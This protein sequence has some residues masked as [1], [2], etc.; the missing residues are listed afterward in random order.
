MEEVKS[1]FPPFLSGAPQFK[2]VEPLSP[3]LKLKPKK[4]RREDPSSQDAEQKILKREEVRKAIQMSQ[5]FEMIEVHPLFAA[6]RLAARPGVLE[7]SRVK[8]V[9]PTSHGLTLQDGSSLD[10]DVAV[11]ASRA[12]TV[13]AQYVEEVPAALIGK[14]TLLITQLLHAGVHDSPHFAAIV[15]HADGKIKAV[16]ITLKGT[17]SDLLN[18]VSD[19]DDTDSAYETLEVGPI[20]VAARTLN[21]AYFQYETNTSRVPVTKETLEDLMFTQVHYSSFEPNEEQKQS[22]NLRQGI[23][24]RAKG[25]AN[26]QNLLFIKKLGSQATPKA[27]KAS[28]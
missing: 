11:F 15:P 9:H 5:K 18:N 2:P 14:E 6:G 27:N 24:L 3:K 26:D 22:K 1:P 4:K 20:A 8:A 21:Q 7:F 28:S 19:L 25:E 10:F 17:I 13:L 16:P 12:F 23:F